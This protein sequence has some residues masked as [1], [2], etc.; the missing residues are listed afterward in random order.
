MRAATA[1]QGTLEIK[2]RWSSAWMEKPLLYQQRSGRRLAILEEGR[3]IRIGDFA[4]IKPGVDE[5]R[6]DGKPTDPFWVGRVCA[7]DHDV[8]GIY[9]QWYSPK[10]GRYPFDSPYQPSIWVD[11]K[12]KE[13]VVEEEEQEEEK[14]EEKEEKEEKSIRN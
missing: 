3:T 8:R 14:K 11:E 4:V 9:V 13:E 1:E 2:S 10:D 12:D 5:G 7:Y 6:Q